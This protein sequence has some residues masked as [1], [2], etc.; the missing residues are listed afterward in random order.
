[1]GLTDYWRIARRRWLIIAGVLLLCLIGAAQYIGSASTSYAATSS[2]YVSMATGTSVNDS[3]QGGLA[4][5]QRV[6]SYVDLMTSAE[7]ARRTIAD[8]SLKADSGNPMSTDELRSK[9]T[10]VSPPATTLINVTVRDSSAQRAADIANKLVAQFRMF[11]AELESI[12][13]DAAPAARVE[14]VDRAEVPTGATG[15]QSTRIYAL[16]VLIGLSLGCLVAYVRDRADRKLRT[17]NGLEA[18]L[19]VPI[20]GIIDVGR[21]GA[22][23]ETRRL[24]ARL[25]RNGEATTVLMTSLSAQSEPDI[26]MA[27]AKSFADAGRRV[28]YID[29]DTSGGGGSKQVVVGTTPGL[30]GVLRGST[31]VSE[32]L[33]G[34]PQAG[35]TVLPLGE[36]DEHTPDLLASDRFAAVVAKLRTD[37]EHV[38]VQ[39]APVAHAADAVALAPLCEHT[40]GVVEL[41]ATTAPQLRG[42]LATFGDNTLTGAVAYSKL[43]NRLQRLVGR[44]RL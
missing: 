31:P 18:V 3:Y 35:L 26:A 17:S 24:R 7:V 28:V 4:A 6:R 8:L 30:A 41:G 9:V 2:M 40:V 32:A 29:A 44:L 16:G 11:I 12:E 20:L 1:M 14:V 23:D 13:K 21:P 33:T 5:Q 39:T 19:P 15:P 10:A 38:V 34:W 27:L 43:G 42:A 22:A 36:A 37:Y 25:Q